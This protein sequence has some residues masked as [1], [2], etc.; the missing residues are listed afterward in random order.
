MEKI[1]WTEKER[2]EAKQE[3][4]VAHLTVAVATGDAKARAEDDLSKTRM[5][6]Q[7]RRKTGAG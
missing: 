6:W 7:I 2:D 4:K 3:A 1:E 5:P